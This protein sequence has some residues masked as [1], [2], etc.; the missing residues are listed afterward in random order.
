MKG[1]KLYLRILE[2]SDLVRTHAWIN[3]PVIGEIMGLMPSSYKSQ[4][5]WF[6]KA[7]GD[8]TRYIF[9][10]CLNGT[11]EHIGNVAVTHIDSIHRHGLFSIFIH[12]EK[13]RRSGNGT[14][15]TRLLLDFAFGRLNLNKV[16][17]KMSDEYVEARAMYESLGFTRDGVLIEHEFRDGVYHDKV[18]YS[19]LKRNYTLSN[20][21]QS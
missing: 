15:A 2:E 6:A 11:G 21:R 7:T 13:H 17:L 14:E 8:P 5:D 4:V 10:I 1:Q 12:D 3:D 20:V 19:I 16:H 9:A 18:I